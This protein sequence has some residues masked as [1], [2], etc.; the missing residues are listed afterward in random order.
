M[1]AFLRLAVSQRENRP[2][3]SAL[4]H[5]AIEPP[6]PIDLSNFQGLSSFDDL[7]TFLGTS[8]RRLRYLL[9]S[10]RRPAYRE[11]TLP[12]RAG[13]VRA[14]ASP[15][16][17]IALYQHKL[18]ACMSALITPKRAVHGFVAGR[19]VATNARRHVGAR[20]LLNV[21][22][23]DFFPSIHF[24]R[25]QGIFRAR[26]F[27]FPGS[28]SA[29]LAHI[30]C[31]RGVLPQGAATSPLLSNL[32]CRGLDRDLSRFAREHH[33]EYTRYADDITISTRQHRFARE[34]V[35]AMPLRRGSSPTLGAALKQVFI[36]HDF[37]LNAA[38]TRV[39]ARHERQV[40]TGL[41]V[42]ETVNVR[43]DYVR[44]VRA[45]LHNCATIGIPNANQRFH[46]EF[47]T[48]P[49]RG[50][51]P[52]IELYIRGKLNYLRMVKGPNDPVYF[53][54]AEKAAATIP[55]L[56]RGVPVSGKLALQSDTLEKAVWI[57]VGLS[58][59]GT[60]VAQGTAFSLREVG[61]VSARHVFDSPTPSG[62]AVVA[63]LIFRRSEPARRF[64]VTA[65]RTHQSL[66]LAIVESTAL[67]T[68]LLESTE[69]EV[70]T[71]DDLLVA[72]YP[73]WRTLADKIACIR[74]QATQTIT[75]S[76]VRFIITSG[77]LR[78][79]NSGGPIMNG[80]GHVVAVVVYDHSNSSTPNAGITI[81]HLTA[82]R[83][84]S[85]RSL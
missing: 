27:A 78:A 5:V 48:K 25:V 36:D 31:W 16:P 6:S 12:K 11:F 85:P 73:Q 65:I 24:G 9:Y 22:I 34:L 15:P 83:T 58:S 38:K 53:R 84:V 71:G 42:N 54:L 61:I 77:Q 63:W 18:L 47:D 82:L 72:G 37:K 45:M 64:K 50:S 1:P 14:I 43:R 52:S 39:N 60:E 23:L 62:H 75:V 20:L 70:R 4:H 69:E 33:A 67:S 13:G 32:V 19:S 76:A 81:D 79:G 30:C 17:I 3:D 51:S 29:V 59:D 80:S 44:N 21:D 26:P 10:P 49:R 56:A 68:V 40:V 8:P 46:S 28:L 57:V 2:P 66:D 41:V 55:L 35:E 74:C 7:A